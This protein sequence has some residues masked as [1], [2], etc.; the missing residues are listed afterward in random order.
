MAEILFVCTGNICRSP[1]AEGFT[2]AE[3]A[4]RGITGIGVASSGVSAWTD[5]SATAESVDALREL[6]VDISAHRA[7]R[8]EPSMLGQAESVICMT[9]G[10]REAIVHTAPA[11]ADKA[12]TLKEVVHLLAAVAEG[13]P[14]EGD[15]PVE[16]LRRSV[17]AA[18]A[19][20]AGGR[21]EEPI[22]LD[23]ADPIG[24]GAGTYRATA[25]EVQD[26]C[27]RMVDGL[28]RIPTGAGIRMED[29]ARDGGIWGGDVA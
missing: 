6:G 10:Q 9:A 18:A 22:D 16:Q 20:R 17:A 28:F 21:I 7:R 13:A 27:R 12:F 14:A 23:V 5:S 24:L 26:L 19:L 15:S 1:M 11:V 8:V 4:R 29:R 25:W 3:L 2:R